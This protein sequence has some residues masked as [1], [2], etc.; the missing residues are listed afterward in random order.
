VGIGKA[1]YCYGGRQTCREG[2]SYEAGRETAQPS[3]EYYNKV[4]DYTRLKIKPT[5]AQASSLASIRSAKTIAGT[6]WSYYW[7]A[8]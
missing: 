2:R 6:P 3:G 7:S 4:A 1:D 5:G 8:E